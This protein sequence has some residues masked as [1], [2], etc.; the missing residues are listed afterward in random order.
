MAYFHT[1]VQNERFS[2]TFFTLNK[3]ST[4]N[5]S[6]ERRSAIKIQSWYRSLKVQKH[7]KFLQNNATKIQKM[8]KAYVTRKFYREQVQKLMSQLM[9]E[10]YDSLAT[11]IQARWRGYFVRKY[12]ADFY[13]RKAYLDALVVKN[14]T[15]LL[16]LKKIDE[17]NKFNK[18][19]EMVE[20][21]NAAKLYENR[22]T[23]YL[24]STNVCR[25]VYNSPQNPKS[26][27]EAA[28][29]F[30]APLS[31]AEREN[32]ESRK[33]ENYLKTATGIPQESQLELSK[34]KDKVL[35]PIKSVKPQ[36]PFREPVEVQKQRFKPLLP[37]LRVATD[38]QS[39][40]EART[41]LRQQEWTKEIIDQ[42]FL[43]SSKQIY[44]Y[45]PTLHASTSYGKVNYGTKHFRDEL[46][47]D[48][49]QK[50]FQ[51]VVSPIPYFDQLGKTY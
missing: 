42:P 44:E 46:K 31:A 8:Y 9:K 27:K 14:E 32:L 50:S 5:G 24:L 21:E 19:I 2:K 33:R 16:K 4:A 11:K 3:D 25:G 36:G 18:E 10:Y 34:I 48:I 6:I 47:R 1:L 43:P 7:I 22:K 13:T 20:K 39:V 40:E 26:E 30:V 12:K 41:T 15:V 29:S 37:T 17:V 28:L 38:Y 51:R 35:P 45:Q 23:H 49:D